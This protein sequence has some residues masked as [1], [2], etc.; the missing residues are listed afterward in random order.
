MI[1]ETPQGSQQVTYTC[2]DGYHIIAGNET[3][4]CLTNGTWLGQT[5]TC[6]SRSYININ[7]D[8]YTNSTSLFTFLT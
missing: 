1:S 7:F 5:P 8:I 6:G 2:D 4:V 3:M